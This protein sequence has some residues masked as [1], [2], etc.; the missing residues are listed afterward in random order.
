MSQSSIGL[1]G[2]GIDFSTWRA[3][4]HEKEDE[5]PWPGPRPLRSTDNPALL[6]G[7][8][9]DKQ[10]FVREVRDRRLVFLTGPTGVGK[11]SLLEVGLAGEL[12]AARYVVGICRNWAGSADAEDPVDFLAAKVAAAFDK[13]LPPSV[14][15][16]DVFWTLDE[17]YSNKGVIVLDQFEELL[18]DSP[19]LRDAV[20]EILAE[21]N[22]E[23]E[24][25]II[26]SFRSEFLQ[27][28]KQLERQVKPF[29]MS[30]VALTV[31]EDEYAIDVITAANKLGES[32][33]IDAAP[34]GGSGDDTSCAG[35]V[36][37]LW[38]SAVTAEVTKFRV[39]RGERIG[40]LHLQ[41]MLYVLSFM[42]GKGNTVGHEHLGALRSSG[43]K[44]ESEYDLFSRSLQLAV[45]RKI[46]HCRAA[47]AGIDQWLLDGTLGTLAQ[48]VRHLSSAGYK[49]IRGIS[50][51]ANAA[52]ED[53]IGDL[54]RAMAESRASEDAPADGPCSTEDVDG[55]ITSIV[56]LTLTSDP[57]K[58]S[59]DLLDSPM[60]VI[61]KAVDES[62]ASGDGSRGDF[63]SRR[64]HH[65]TAP[66]LADPTGVTSGPMLGMAP[67]NVLIEELRRF[68]FAVAWLSASDLARLSTPGAG[69]ANVALIHDGFGSAL[70]KWSARVRNEPASVLASITAPKG[71]EFIWNRVSHNEVTHL[72]GTPD[73]PDVVLNQRW[74][75]AWIEADLKWV[76]FVGCDLRGTGFGYSTFEGVT[77]VNCLLDGA[78]FTDTTIVGLP[79]EDDATSFKNEEPEFLIRSS[80]T[81]VAALNRYRET[82]V[83]SD[84]LHI[85]LPGLPAEPATEADGS[86]TAVPHPTGG[87]SIYGG[88][89]S[90][91]TLRNLDMGKSA[92]LLFASVAGSGIDVVEQRGGQFQIAS[93]AVRHLTISPPLPGLK[94]SA[95]RQ[96]DSAAADGSNPVNIDISHTA[97]VQTWISAGLKGTV[98][99]RDCAVVQFWNDSPDV[100]VVAED[101]DYYDLVGVDA[102]QSRPF[103]NDDSA[104]DRA[105][106]GVKL[107]SRFRR[108]T[109][110]RDA[111][112]RDDLSD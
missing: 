27:D 84:E 4:L 88:R 97:L 33:A 54:T 106:T 53:Q 25:K 108:M 99:L 66:R 23:T 81:F 3:R 94:G 16:A 21:L 112:R 111:S 47:A 67:A 6:V 57:A 65:G 1:S 51:L 78:L 17:K 109:Y 56:D 10:N 95:P 89:I 91:L 20:F 49:L 18:R 90:A 31:I 62:L 12:R 107:A 60:S 75:G 64:L 45:D 103:G 87:L 11:T 8:A 40:L 82:S 52:L 38:Q 105:N 29:T 100:Q 61:A 2:S 104:V 93:S 13:H 96:P 63:W 14:S 86:L 15:G 79:P 77:F 30:H 85:P 34:E 19:L 48:V 28:L 22:E 39:G 76:T 68:A 71:G 73:R 43:P 26:V 101:C 110:R 70:E 59:V 37:R 44:D 50:D 24:L 98:Q 83:D 36:A 35:L 32:P 41:A 46:E 92:R 74:K 72:S 58:A 5:C 9:R 42:A 55:L 102:G 7:R 69:S 80:E